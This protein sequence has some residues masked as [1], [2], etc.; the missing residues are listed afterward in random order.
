VVNTLVFAP[1]GTG[2]WRDACGATSREHRRDRCGLPPDEHRRDMC[3]AALDEQNG[4]PGI[5][6]ARGIERLTI[7]D[8]VTATPR[9]AASSIRD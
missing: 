8:G 6:P 3:G 7:V 1:T 4:R 5:D 9:D 2:E